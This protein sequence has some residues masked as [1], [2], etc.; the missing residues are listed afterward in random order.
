MGKLSEQ[1][2]PDPKKHFFSVKKL[3]EVRG[4]ALACLPGE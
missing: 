3:A 4:V 2:K 1:K